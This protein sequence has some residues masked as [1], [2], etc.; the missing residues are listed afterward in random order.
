MVARARRRGVPRSAQDVLGACPPAR[1]AAAECAPSP[2]QSPHVLSPRRVPRDALYARADSADGRVSRAHQ[3][4]SSIAAAGYFVL[5]YE[6]PDGREHAF[7][8]VSECP[9]CA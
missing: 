8:G 3:I 7:S 9:P 4:V 1:P 5:H 2:L 6:H